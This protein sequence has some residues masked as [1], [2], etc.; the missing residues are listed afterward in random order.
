MVKYNYDAWGTISITQDTSS[1]DIGSL[2]PFRYKGYYYDSESGM[3]Y[4]ETRYYVPSC[5]R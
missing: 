1:S 2:N 4:C 3:Y 5:G